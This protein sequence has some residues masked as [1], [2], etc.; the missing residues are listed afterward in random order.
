ML[1]G[2][3]GPPTAAMPTAS[4]PPAAMAKGKPWLDPQLLT[5][6]TAV[7][8]HLEVID[9]RDAKLLRLK[10][11]IQKYV[12]LQDQQLTIVAN[13]A[14]VRRVLD[15]VSEYFKDVD[16]KALD[17]STPDATKRKSM[18]SFETGETSI[19]VMASEI[20]T[21]RDFDFTKP[22]AV[23]V[24]FDFPMTLQLYLHRLFKRAESNTHVYTF[25]SPQYNIRNTVPLVLTLEG[26][27]Q[28]VPPALQKLKDQMKN[29]GKRN[30]CDV[31]TKKGCL[32]SEKE[33]LAKFE[34]KSATIVKF[35]LKTMKLQ[36]ETMKR[37]RCVLKVL[38]A[39]K[40][41][42]EE[43][44]KAS[45]QPVPLDL[46]R[47]TAAELMANAE[48]SATQVAA[49]STPPANR[50]LFPT[51]PRAAAEIAAHSTV[52]SHAA[53][54]HDGAKHAMEEQDDGFADFLKEFQSL[55]NP[56]AVAKKAAA[57]ATEP[58]A[59]RMR[60]ENIGLS[61]LSEPHLSF[62]D[63]L[64]KKHAGQFSSA[65]ITQPTVKSAASSSVSMRPVSP[66]TMRSTSPAQTASATQVG[67]VETPAGGSVGA[68]AGTPTAGGSMQIK[69]AGSLRVQDRMDMVDAKYKVALPKAIGDQ[70]K[71]VTHN[72]GLPD[73]L[74]DKMGSFAEKN[75]AEGGIGEDDSILDVIMQLFDS[76]EDKSAIRKNMPRDL[77]MKHWASVYS[78]VTGRWYKEYKGNNRGKDRGHTW[79][80]R[81][82]K[83]MRNS[84]G[85]TVPA[86]DPDTMHTADPG[87]SRA[88]SSS[89]W[90]GA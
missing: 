88:S 53:L 41:R 65:I 48:A 9:D 82:I 33:I 24:N 11:L 64:E 15:M 43:A 66:V 38:L 49:P 68:Q 31:V 45:L 74:C 17:C 10:A 71:E 30:A 4:N 12:F 83:P 90:G 32:P 52:A 18:K 87:S 13:S 55:D 59:K 58:P 70:L 27:K 78:I 28:K 50:R 22:A 72:R 36:L 60:K 37:Q 34:K 8:H 14:N 5:T 6:L 62:L 46:A 73:T 29:Q 69:A 89:A 84:G 1:R 26:A 77:Y 61:F 21:R 3:S 80:R 2:A 16:C 42:E 7:E 76:K 51:P 54:A 79:R 75:L 63:S 39:R 44:R 25:F 35:H 19:L 86:V 40:L 57:E 85:I 67:T 56:E 23:L 81:P 47:E 20:S